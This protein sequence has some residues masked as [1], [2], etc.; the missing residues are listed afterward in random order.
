M[1]GVSAKY[2][3]GKEAQKKRADYL[4][5]KYQFKSNFNHWQESQNKNLE[6]E[7]YHG[8]EYDSI[9]FRNASKLI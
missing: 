7:K 6:R 2:W 8:N 3:S 5:D 4:P 1:K 9:N